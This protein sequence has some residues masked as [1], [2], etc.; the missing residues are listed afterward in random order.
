MEIGQMMGKIRVDCGIMVGC[1]CLRKPIWYS[2]CFLAVKLCKDDK[3]IHFVQ[4]IIL[5]VLNL[6]L[7][8]QLEI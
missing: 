8:E 3:L 7:D 5:F 2:E 4:E 1:T 6:S